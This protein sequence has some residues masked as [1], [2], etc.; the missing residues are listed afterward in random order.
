MKTILRIFIVL[1]VAGL[2]GGAAGLIVKATD[3]PASVASANQAGVPAANGKILN[4]EQPTPGGA[5]AAQK[6][7]ST[8][9]ITETLKNLLKTASIV[10]GVWVIERVSKNKRRKKF[11]SVPIRSRELA[12]LRVS[13]V[14]KRFLTPIMMSSV[15]AMT[16]KLTE[17]D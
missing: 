8:F 17:A 3:K 13:A 10:T 2:I 11:V 14:G 15:R 16:N 7:A 12:Q 4:R 1:L 9:S 6:A 5:G